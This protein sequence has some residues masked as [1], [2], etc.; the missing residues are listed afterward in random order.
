MGQALDR[1]FERPGR[2]LT[3]SSPVSGRKLFFALGLATSVRAKLLCPL[4]LAADSSQ[5]RT[6]G[7]FLPDDLGRFPSAW[8]SPTPIMKKTE[9]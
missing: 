8:F 5:E 1:C 6:Y 9:K 3:P 2:R 7:A 4:K